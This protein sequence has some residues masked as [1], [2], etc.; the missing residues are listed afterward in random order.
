MNL[1][2][3]KEIN[4]TNNSILDAQNTLNMLGRQLRINENFFKSSTVIPR[5]KSTSA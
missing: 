5:R 4:N 1:N 2:L 3:N